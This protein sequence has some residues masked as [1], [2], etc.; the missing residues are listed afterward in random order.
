MH[1][2]LPVEIIGSVL[3]YLPVPDLCRAAR[4]S[5][6]F[7]DLVYNE[8]RWINYLKAVGVWSDVAARQHFEDQAFRRQQKING[9][10]AAKDARPVVDRGDTIYDAAKLGETPSKQRIGKPESD[11]LKFTPKKEDGR[12]EENSSIFSCLKNVRSVRGKAR[13]EF[14]SVWTHLYPIYED[15]STAANPSNSMLF[16][17]FRLPEDQ[18]RMLR[19]LASFAK[20]N[21]V[22]AWPQKNAKLSSITDL[23]EN[24]A[25]REFEI[26]YDNRDEEL[27]RRYAKV[28]NLLNGGQ[29]CVKAFCR[30]NV[31]F[32][33]AA[34]NPFEC[35]DSFSDE[36]AVNLAPMGSMLDSLALE[37]TSQEGLILRI[38]Q[39]TQF[40]WDLFVD[41][42][43]SHLISDYISKLVDY[44]Q[45]QNTHAYL[46]ALTGSYQH[47][48]NLVTRLSRKTDDN[49]VDQVKLL[50]VPVKQSSAD[51]ADP[52]LLRLLQKVYEE[53]VSYYLEEEV[54]ELRK[55]VIKEVTNW[56]KQIKDESQQTEELLL[57][58]VNREVA[59]KN[60]LQ[61]FTK[62]ILMPVN[63]VGSVMPFPAR[64]TTSTDSSQPAAII[65]GNN[66]IDEQSKSELPTTEL[67]ARAAIMNSGLARIKRLLSLEVALQLIHTCK[68]SIDRARSFVK[69]AGRTGE[70][71]RE[72]CEM[73]F[74]IM[75]SSLGARHVQGGFDLAL[76]SLKDFNPRNNKEIGQV[77][78][79][80]DFLELV[81]VGDLIQQMVD[82]FYNQELSGIVDKS[83]FLSPAVKEKKKFEQMID[84][85][86]AEGLNR[87][88]DVLMEQIDYILVTTQKPTDFKP[89]LVLGKDDH[90]DLRESDTAVAVV[91]CLT[92]HTELL[93]G[94]TDKS[95]LDV[96]FQEVGVRFFGSLCKHFKRQSIT[97]EGGLKLI[98]DLN[99][100]YQFILTLKQS[101][102]V[103]YFT[104]LK[105]L[106]NIYIIS[107]RDGKAVGQVI[108]DIA[109]FG[110]VLRP[111]DVYE[112]AE[113][114]A[115]WNKVKSA[116]DRV[117]YGTKLGE[118]CIIS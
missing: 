108:S 77:Q 111:E 55:N 51:E 39:D 86:V 11:L 61:S 7:K 2:D 32:T 97:V 53:H 67:A 84:E 58:G 72:Q 109:R 22:D 76:D 71:T 38:F 80:V 50:D 42:I 105:E 88:I 12:A 35:F 30:K 60:F 44:A 15:L 24:A 41:R 99:Y 106:G 115:D 23:F 92:T 26:G 91:D 64:P 6:L 113:R 89:W 20:A 101:S 75:I 118:D 40:A 59:K 79:L 78:P 65:A 16:R 73:M 81:H 56:D 95:T 82:V 54:S 66:E 37:M 52:K 70:E 85:K 103:P 104:A 3:D 29:S 33:N 114:R 93:R 18:A 100:Y 1:V 10:K 90:L 49:A 14:A 96:F 13:Q 69:F 43:F 110:G 4:V 45:Q 31:L 27:M 102:I 46:L 25:L 9:K 68:V 107:G 116:V 112:F 48:L 8:E 98:S 47:L 34:P 19:Q 74:G 17:K 63:V 57:S 5:L 36:S 117:I 94:S 28:L 62:V 87:G 21:A 83:D